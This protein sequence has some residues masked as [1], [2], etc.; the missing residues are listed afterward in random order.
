MHLQFYWLHENPLV[1]IDT[2]IFNKSKMIRSE[3]WPREEALILTMYL[4]IYVK[5]ERVSKCLR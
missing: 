1:D 5:S 4:Y 3:R 2:L